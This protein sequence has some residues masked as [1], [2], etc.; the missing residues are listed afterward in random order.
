MATRK[1]VADRI[2]RGGSPNE[3]IACSFW[4]VDDIFTQAGEMHVK[5]TEQEA[6]EIIQR[7][8]EG[9]NATTGINWEVIEYHIRN[10]LL[11]KKDK[12]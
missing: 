1:E 8:D 11:A 6:K 12:K 5:V 7:I 10:F 4:T 2:L 9:K 3:Q